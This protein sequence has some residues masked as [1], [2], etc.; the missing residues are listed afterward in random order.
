MKKLSAYITN[1]H[2]IGKELLTPRSRSTVRI[3]PCR[4]GTHLDVFGRIA[5]PVGPRGLRARP[6]G[7]P[8]GDPGRPPPQVDENLLGVAHQANEDR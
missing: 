7:P 5:R 6:Q 2:L 3:T 1:S 4:K 8:A